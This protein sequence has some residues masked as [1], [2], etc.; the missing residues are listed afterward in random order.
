MVSS[1]FKPQRE[2]PGGR[3]P[4]R[5]LVPVPDA[6]PEAMAAILAR[7]A[8]TR[9]PGWRPNNY[10]RSAMYR[11][12]CRAQSAKRRKRE[13]LARAPQPWKPPLSNREQERQ[14][15]LRRIAARKAARAKRPPQENALED[16]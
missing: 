11:E 6:V 14:Y 2:R 7:E 9:G 12:H 5:A 4:S 15:Q 1:Q 10:E 13:K 16:K 8:K 3:R